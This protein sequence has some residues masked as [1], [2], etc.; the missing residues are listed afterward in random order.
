MQCDFQNF[1]QIE[2]SLQN[3]CF[4]SEGSGFHTAGGSSTTCILNGFPG[5]QQLLNNRLRIVEG[6]LSPALSTDFTCSLDK[7]HRCLFGDLYVAG[8]LQQ[9]H[10]I[11]NIQN[12]IGYIIDP[13]FSIRCNPSGIDIRKIRI[14]GGFLQRDAHLWRSRLIVEFHPQTFQKLLCLGFIQTSR[15]D[16]CFIKRIQMLIQTS[17]GVCIPWIQLGCHTEVYKPVHLNRLP[18]GLRLMCRNDVTVCGNLQQFF[19]TYRVTFLF[20]KLSG[21]RCIAFSQNHDGIAHN[22]HTT[23]LIA[24][25]D[26]LRIV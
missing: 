17:R 21:Q 26:C 22:T 5:I 20:R 10:F 18:V 24:F 11:H 7:F 16:I 3:V 2:I 13:V 1:R 9:L 4:P 8:W 25:F 14:S 23:Q 15:F 12:Q 6:R 19:L